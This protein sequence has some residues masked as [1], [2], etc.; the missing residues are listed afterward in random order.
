MRKRTENVRRIQSNYMNKYDMHQERQ[1]RRQRLLRRR[2]IVF[3]IILFIT[4][5]A[6]AQA[7][8]EKQSLHAKK[9]QEYEQLQQQFTALDE[10]ESKLLEEINLLQDEDY[11]LRIAKTNYFFTKEGEIVFKLTEETP[12]Y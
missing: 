9:Q 4:I 10:E 5:V 7:Y 11:I 2:L 1:R 12:S 3:G 6:F 8:I